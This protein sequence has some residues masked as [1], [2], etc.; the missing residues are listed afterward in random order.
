MGSVRIS[1]ICHYCGGKATTEDHIVPRCDLPPGIRQP[2]W[3]RSNNVVPSCSP[4]NNSK[5]CLRSDCGCPHCDWAWAT[6]L[7]RFL[8]LGYEPHGYVTLTGHVGWQVS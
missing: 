8:P 6:A 4:C 7:A 2:Y 5:G 3:F 1:Q